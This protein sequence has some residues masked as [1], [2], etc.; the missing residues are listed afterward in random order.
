VTELQKSVALEQGNIGNYII[1]GRIFRWQQKVEE[2][3]K[4]YKKA[5]E[6][7]PGNTEAMVGLGRVYLNDDQW[8]KAE[9]L[10]LKALDIDPNNLDAKEALEQLRKIKAPEANIRY[11]FLE[12]RSHDRFTGQIG[13]TFID[14]RGTLESFFKLSPKSVFQVRYQHGLSKELGPS[15]TTTHFKVDTDTASV[16]LYQKLPSNFNLRFRFDLS[17]FS[18][19]D[20][21]NNTSNLQESENDFAGYFILTKEYRR[22]LWRV[23]LGRELFVDSNFGFSTF[24][25]IENINTYSISYDAGIT[26]FFTTLVVLSLSDN[27]TF[28]KIQQ[29]HAF[30]A[31]YRLPKYQKVE[32][33]YQFRY[34]SNPDV[35]RNTF[36]INFQNQ[37]SR[38]FRYEARYAF[39]A[40]NSNAEFED[41]LR[42]SVKLFISWD[43]NPWLAWSTDAIASLDHL[44]GNDDYILNLQTYLTIRF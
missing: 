44:N 26:D 1:L 34:L 16:G 42:N 37:I 4:L 43:I 31:R 22:H 14:H 24:S 23:T 25:T 5:L 29:D 39:T 27:S 38:K 41:F 9:E 33:E 18:N 19:N 15:N 32:F 10:Y 2:S 3:I 20:S 17:R 6:L 35:Y 28:Q 12:A 7:D 21:A 30:R 40:S 8:D 36:G 13:T 11:N